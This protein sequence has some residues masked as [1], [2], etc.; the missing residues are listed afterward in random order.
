MKEFFRQDN[1]KKRFLLQNGGKLLK[2]FS[3]KVAPFLEFLVILINEQ[4]EKSEG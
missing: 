1:K 3:K 4:D 2:I